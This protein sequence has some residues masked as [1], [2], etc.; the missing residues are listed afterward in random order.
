MQSSIKCPICGVPSREI[1]KP[2]GGRGRKI[3]HCVACDTV[4]TYPMFSD[5]KVRSNSYTATFGNLRIGKGASFS[6]SAKFIESVRPLRRD[7]IVLDIGVNRGHFSRY[8]AERIDAMID[9][10]EPDFSIVLGEDYTG[11]Y[12]ANAYGV[13]VYNTRIEDAWLSDWDDKRYSFVYMSHVLEHVDDPVAVL[14]KI[15]GLMLDDG[16]L[17][18]EVPNI[19]IIKGGNLVEEFF[20]NKHRYHFSVRS[21]MNVLARGGFHIN[22]LSADEDVIFAIASQYSQ[23]DLPSNDDYDAIIAH[24]RRTMEINDHIAFRSVK[25]LNE[26][27]GNGRTVIWGAGRIFSLLRFRG[28]EVEKAKAVVDTYMAGMTIDGVEIKDPSVIESG[29]DVIICA[30]EYYNEISNL[31]TEKGAIPHEWIQ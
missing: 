29:D 11:E 4:F 8:A 13:V 25:K 3:Y 9:G 14:R 26:L 24:Y 19:D 12:V 17:Y 5:D 20:I 7:D 15:R 30:R 23:S 2:I 22:A 31:V 6:R 28:L 16:A 1:Y 21:L 18:I 10:I 27:I